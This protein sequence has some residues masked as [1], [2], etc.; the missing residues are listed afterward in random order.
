MK[1]FDDVSSMSIN[2]FSQGKVNEIV[3][4]ELAAFKEKIRARLQNDIDY[5]HRTGG[6]NADY[7]DARKSLLDDPLLR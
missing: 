4:A 2:G 5:W 1:S 3:R 7:H 6:M